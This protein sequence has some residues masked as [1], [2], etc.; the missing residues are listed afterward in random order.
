MHGRGHSMASATEVVAQTG[1]S[2]E[3]QPLRSRLFM[4]AAGGLLPLAIAALLGAV[5]LVQQ[6]RVEAQREA[7]ELSRAL[8]TAV[9]VELKSTISA[10]Q[11][12]AASDDL[13]GSRLE[14][15]H[16]LAQRVARQQGWRNVL[17]ADANGAIVLS[18]NLPIGQAIPS[19]PLDPQSMQRAIASRAPVIGRVVA[20]QRLPG[21]AFAVRVPVVRDGQLVN[22]LTA[23]V[24][25][26][27]LLNVL[28]R[29]NV[30]STWVVAIFDQS[31]DRVARTRFN[32]TPRPSRSLQVMLDTGAAE[33]MGPTETLEGVS[34]FSGFSRLKDSGW[35]VAV[36][37]PARE[38][39]MASLPLLLSL[40]AGLLA[41]LSLSAWLAWVFA[42]RVS[43]AHRQAQ[44]RGR[45][46]GTRRSCRLARS[47]GRRT[48]RS[49]R[50]PQPCFG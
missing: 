13:S 7:L 31:G 4:L 29:Q 42:R 3:S 6:R 21:S 45:W 46:P 27:Q 43:P 12:L 28:T 36:G 26:D 17:L 34:S 9:D 48:R 22:V 33:G 35:I 40:A 19:A 49:G 8:A 20:G 5:Y 11:V 2:R 32:A 14:P 1:G 10:L 25:T 37:I 15:F 23:V 44:E 50:G 38:V 18:G 30:P 24:S 41:S 47:R 39:W 16:R